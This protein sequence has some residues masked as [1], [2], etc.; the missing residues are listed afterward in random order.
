MSQSPEAAFAAALL[1]RGAAV[2]TGL[3]ARPGVAAADRF[4]IYRN[5]VFAGLTAVLAARF[6]TCRRL[7]GPEFFAFM[8]GEFIA[9]HPPLAPVLMEY[10]A[11]LPAFLDRFAPIRALAYLPDVARLEW[12]IHIAACGADAFPSEVH[13]L[14]ALP[15]DVMQDIRFDLHPTLGLLGSAFPVVSIWRANRGEPMPVAAGLPGEHALVLR[16]GED[17]EIHAVP[18]VVADFIGDLRAGSTLGAAAARDIDLTA[19]LTLL[20]RL[21]AVTGFA[22]HPPFQTRKG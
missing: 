19:T 3:I 6:P 14:G 5:N 21:G 16:V 12:L 22:V 13:R 4:R 2:P 8:A 7:V 10:G 1:D 18:A 20:F 11:G 17:V 9:A 15:P